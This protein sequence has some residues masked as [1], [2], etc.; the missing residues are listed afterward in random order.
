M[1]IAVLADGISASNAVVT[2]V[3]SD[4]GVAVISPRLAIHDL[5]RLIKRDV[6]VAINRLQFA[7]VPRLAQCMPTQT[8]VP[9][10]PL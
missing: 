5:P 7:F 3:S 10:V 2:V 4:E 9:P 6:H 1:T 8:A